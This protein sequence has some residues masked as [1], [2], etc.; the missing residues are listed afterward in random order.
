MGRHLGKQPSRDPAHFRY[1][2][3]KRYQAGR[4]PSFFSPIKFPLDN[5]LAFDL[6]SFELFATLWFR[7]NVFITIPCMFSIH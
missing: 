6:A 5:A 2:V 4:A 3:E 7:V 1:N